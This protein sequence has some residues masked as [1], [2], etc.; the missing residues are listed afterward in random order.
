[1]LLSAKLAFGQL[2]DDFSDGNFTVNPVWSGHASQ[3]I[4]N[5]ARQLQTVL[6]AV[7]QNVMLSTPSRLALNVQWEFYI[8]LNFDPSAT[9]QARIYLLSDQADLNGPLN[10]YFIQIGE[11]G[12][13]DSYDLYR[14]TGNT[15]TR[16]ID[17]QAKVRPDA[18]KLMARVRVTRNGAGQWELFTDISGGTAYNLEGT[19][20]DLTH[21]FT[22]WFGVQCR[23]TST[24]SN[25]F[26]FDDFRISELV[27]DV[28]PPGLISARVTDEHTIEAVFSERLE[29]SSAMLASNYSVTNVFN[30]ANILSTP[31]P[32]I[33]H[34]KYNLPLPSGDYKLTVTGVTDLK[35]NRIGADNSV[36]FFYLQPYEL[37]KGDLLISEILFNP[38]TGGV[39]FVEIYNATNQ[40]IDL[41]GL[42]LANADAGGN[43][44]N[45]KNVSAVSVYMQPKSYWVFTPN[46]AIVKQHYVSKNPD[47]F[48]QMSMPAYNN[49]KGTVFLMDATKELENVAYTAQL[50]FEML[51]NTDGISLERASFNKPANAPG[52]FR[53]AALTI[54]GATPTYRN[55]QDENELTHGAVAIPNKVFSP[56]G[57]G[58]DDLLQIDYQLKASGSLVTV[59]IYTAQ[60]V[61]IR[62]LYQNISVPTAGSLN[63]D[64]KNDAGQTCGVGIYL[65]RFETFTL[66]GKKQHFEKIGI[67]AAKL[68]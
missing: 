65:I 62:K 64:G 59:N 67:L 61:L 55:S 1:M 23:Y 56:D 31:D 45:F 4:I 68:N 3:F 11:S 39:D 53:S 36:S 29:T 47:H 14:Q 42:R 7:N 49:D 32:N 6:S 20:T 25:G 50:H 10:G 24:R 2:S 60:G 12:S 5:S 18:N 51:R 38:K 30:P 48:V 44:A 41:K 37:K 43:P 66:N 52:N 19:V 22:D 17:G 15:T 8:Q 63:W 27:P 26:I 57:D 54:G 58:F 28:T 9:N 46:A 35:G 16:L 34:L 40:V 13:S 33:Y 21:Q